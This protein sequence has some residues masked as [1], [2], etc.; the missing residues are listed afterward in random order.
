MSTSPQ[1]AWDLDSV[2]TE[3]LS[4]ESDRRDRE[5][6]TDD[7]TDLDLGTAYQIQAETLRRRQARGET[8]V[9]IKLGLTSRAKQKRMG[10]DVPLVA[11][12]TDAMVL[13]A[14]EPVPQAA[15]I[16]PRV[17]PEIVFVMG[18]RLQGPGVTAAQALSAVAQVFGGAE[19]IDSRYRNL[20]F[21]LPD[22]VA[23]NASTGAYVA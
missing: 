12:L 19:V 5:P 1:P 18:D 23:D 21:R 10:I 17:E 14:G 3:L 22:V 8:V 4:C 11:W 9:G 15:L 2:A 7:W 13:P 20:R 16:H 6:F